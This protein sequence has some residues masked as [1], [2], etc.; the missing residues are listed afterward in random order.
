VPLIIYAICHNAYFYH[1][2]VRAGS[3]ETKQRDED[4]RVIVKQYFSARTKDQILCFSSQVIIFSFE[5]LITKCMEGIVCVFDPT[6]GTL[7]LNM[8]ANQVPSFL[9]YPQRF[10]FCRIFN[11]FTAFFGPL[12][13][14]VALS[15]RSASATNT[16]TCLLW[17]PY[18]CSPSALCIR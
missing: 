12:L 11:L 16:F 3:F 5:I 13:T 15:T 7:R 8:D 1:A 9:V 10:F 6:D 18:S 17:P 4:T 14:F 2:I